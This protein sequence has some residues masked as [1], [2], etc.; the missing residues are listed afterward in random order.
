MTRR[1]KGRALNLTSCFRLSYHFFGIGGLAK[2]L[3]VS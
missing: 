1:E 2:E 3:L